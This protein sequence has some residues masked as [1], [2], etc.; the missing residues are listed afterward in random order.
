MADAPV[1]KEEHAPA[2]PA[3]TAPPPDVASDP[4][5]DDLSDL[6]DV[7]DDFANT[8]LDSKAPPTTTKSESSAA[9]SSS[10]PGRPE[11]LSPA[12]LLLENED[13]FAKQL[14]QEMEQLLG[15][16]DFGKQFED[17]MK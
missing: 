3:A 10:G 17:I 2:K 4:D 16:G 6:D 12:E 9:P 11:D 14:Q 7:L 15:N 1:K 13:E 5:E 8:K